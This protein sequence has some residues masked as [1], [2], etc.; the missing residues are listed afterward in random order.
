MN[1]FFYYVLAYVYTTQTLI[2]AILGACIGSFLNVMISRLPE[3]RMLSTHRSC[4]PGCGTMIPIY[5]N[6]PIVS[7]LLL[8]GKAR[9][10]SY[11]IPSRYVL[12]EILG[13][14]VAVLI[15][16]HLPFAGY[17]KGVGWSIDIDD[18]FRFL[19]ALV[20]VY[21][22]IVCAWI[23]HDHM[24]IP[25]WISLPMIGFSPL[26]VWLHPDLNAKS[27]A[28]GVLLGGGSLYC[29]A[30]LYYIVRGD[31]GLGMG[32]VKLLAAIGG[33]LGFQSVGPTLFLGSFVGAAFGIS[34]LAMTRS[35]SM[36]TAIPFG[37]FLVFGAFVH[38]FFGNQLQEWLL[39]LPRS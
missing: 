4:C 27:A 39:F 14:V 35:L 23:D 2:A 18:F 1:A 37:P 19:H 29:I 8:L 7:Y 12:M 24:I 38:L 10:C 5:W 28:L 21:L 15:Y 17:I 26:V 16:W 13:A 36:K 33:W 31:I 25:D 32:D 9:C 3:E 6:I 20:F 30:W 34:A 11:R 22:L